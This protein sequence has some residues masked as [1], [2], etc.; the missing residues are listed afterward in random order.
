MEFRSFSSSVGRDETFSSFITLM[1]HKAKENW[2]DSLL[3][4]FEERS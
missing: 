3:E 2:E 1:K 4:A